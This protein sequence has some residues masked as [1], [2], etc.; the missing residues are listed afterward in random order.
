MGKSQP[1]QN[2]LLKSVGREKSSHQLLLDTVAARGLGLKL[3]SG[4]AEVGT[5]RWCDQALVPAPGRVALSSSLWGLRLRAQKRE[6]GVLAI[7]GACAGETLRVP[8]CDAGL[9]PPSHSSQ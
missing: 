3:T 8:A 9:S 2:L 6:V 4:P 1:S 5:R 7:L